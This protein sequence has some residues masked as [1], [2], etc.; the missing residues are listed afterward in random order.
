L[1]AY[2]L[3]FLTKYLVKTLENLN[4][5]LCEDIKNFKVALFKGHLDIESFNLPLIID[6]TGEKKRS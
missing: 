5:Y 3:E 4:K 1:I 6:V 2:N